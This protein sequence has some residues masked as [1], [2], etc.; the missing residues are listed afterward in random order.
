MYTRQRVSARPTPPCG[1]GIWNRQKAPLLSL[2][3]LTQAPYSRSG[4]AANF[5]PGPVKAGGAGEDAC[6]CSPA[7]AAVSLVLS[8]P[9]PHCCRYALPFGRTNGTPVAKIPQGR[10]LPWWWLW[11]P[12]CCR[13]AL[14][15]GR[16][17]GAPVAKILQ[18]RELP[19]WWLWPHV[20]LFCCSSALLCAAAIHC[21]EFARCT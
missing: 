2:I 8:L 4:A 6:R 13:Y 17:N 3:R 18:G 14:R 16:T 12:H 21:Y 15:F 7:M 5:C 19:C 20:S 1:T 11:P 9:P 10:E